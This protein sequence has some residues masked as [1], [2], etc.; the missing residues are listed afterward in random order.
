MLLPK[1]IGGRG[2]V[3]LQSTELARNSGYP[4]SS[5]RLLRP[6]LPFPR[7]CQGQLQAGEKNGQAS[8]AAGSPVSFSSSLS[9]RWPLLPSLRQEKFSLAFLVTLKYVHNLAHPHPPIPDPRVT[10][11]YSHTH[12]CTHEHTCPQLP[13]ANNKLL[14]LVTLA[15]ISLPTNTLTSLLF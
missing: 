3:G 9:G 10:H 8:G 12:S 4:P 11:S 7:H 15:F 1:G 5:P 13:C 6:P 14:S 2:P